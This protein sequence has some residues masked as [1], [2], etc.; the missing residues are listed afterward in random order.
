MRCHWKILVGAVSDHLAKPVDGDGIVDV[1]GR[2]EKLE[3]WGACRKAIDFE[4]LDV[5][6]V[7]AEDDGDFAAGDVGVGV[8]VGADADGNSPSGTCA[9]GHGVSTIEIHKVTHTKFIG[10]ELCSK[11]I[12]VSLFTRPSLNFVGN[13][14]DNR[15]GVEF[16]TLVDLRNE[17]TLVQR[18]TVRYQQA[19]WIADVSPNSL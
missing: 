4:T 3:N 5:F 6:D 14:D 9:L 17:P 18:E 19:S 1:A 16:V 15:D 2:D 12:P 13:L 10:S 11:A 7:A 8:G